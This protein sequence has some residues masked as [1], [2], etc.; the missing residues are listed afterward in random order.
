MAERHAVV[1][2]GAGPTGL[3][4][5][6]L[7]GDEGVDV[8]L[9]ERNETTVNEP[10]GVS[11]D[12]EALRT[13]Q[14]I[15]LADEVLKHV[16]PGYGSH[17]YS[18]AGNCF[19]IVE[20]TQSPYG[21]PRRNAFRQP[22]LERQLREGLSRFPSVTARFGW[23]MQSFEAGADKVSVKIA[24][25]GNQTTEIDCD[26]LVGCDGA[27]SS[28]RTALG[29]ELKGSTFAE[30]WLIVDLENSHNVVR[31]T[32]VFCSP[33]RACITL[34]GPDNTRRYEFKLHPHEKD[35]DLLEPAVVERQIGRAH[36]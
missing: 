13:M 23:Q 20:P 19:A 8:L 1:I 36:V 31:H 28:V 30:R 10:R 26:F 22:I 9:V 32:K 7:L 33:A 18:A 4:L 6:N 5:A 16:V 24:G 27:W 14:A 12:D 25:P 29:V 11:I 21:Y 35:E 34:P 3:T 15:G 2:V 17:Y